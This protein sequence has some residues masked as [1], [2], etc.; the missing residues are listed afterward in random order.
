M[1][2]SARFKEMMVES[3]WNICCCFIVIGT[4]IQLTVLPI[5]DILANIIAIFAAFGRHSSLW[6]KATTFERSQRRV[7]LVK[8]S[9]VHCDQRPQQLW[10]QR[11]YYNFDILYNSGNLCIM[12]GLL[13][14]P[15]HVRRFLEARVATVMRRFVLV[16]RISFIQS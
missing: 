16:V 2:P 7:F 12:P 10:D 3:P 6:T 1:C 13:L 15:V 4:G 14:S 9:T 11:F 8:T 5:G